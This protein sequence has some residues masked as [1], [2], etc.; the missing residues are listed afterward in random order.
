[1]PEATKSVSAPLAPIEFLQKILT[2]E[3]L[4][5]AMAEEIG[6]GNGRDNVVVGIICG[7]GNGRMDCVVSLISKRV[8]AIYQ[9]KHVVGS[10]GWPDSHVVEMASR[11]GR[12][13]HGA[14]RAVVVGGVP[15]GKRHMWRYA[16]Y[17]LKEAAENFV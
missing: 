15:N 7:D 1:M 11:Y 3:F 17:V 5:S 4:S 13:Q 12:A 9:P 16:E 6:M 2:D 8:G 10:G 14:L